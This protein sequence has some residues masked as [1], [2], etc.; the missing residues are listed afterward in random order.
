MTTLEAI[1]KRAVNY[2]EQRGDQI[3]VANISF[4][5]NSWTDINE[6]SPN[7]GRTFKEYSYIFK[8]IAAGMFVLLSFFLVVR[9]IIRWITSDAMDDYQIFEQLPKTIAELEKEYE[10]EGDSLPMVGQASL[11][12]SK[13]Q[14]NSLKLIKEWIKDK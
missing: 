11:M 7:V 2:N 3:E 9:P 13:E 8:Y 5:A 14:E 1:V 10:Q 12:L 6:D 4:A